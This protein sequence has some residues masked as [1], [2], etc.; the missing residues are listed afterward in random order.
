MSYVIKAADPVTARVLQRWLAL[1][2]K[3]HARHIDEFVKLRPLDPLLCWLVV[4][5]AVPVA[6]V[7]NALGEY[8]WGVVARQ[9]AATP[10]PHRIRFD[11]VAGDIAEFRRRIDW[12]LSE[13][14]SA[15]GMQWL[16]RGDASILITACEAALEAGP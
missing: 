4:M 9:D 15:Y 6:E 14:E 3:K 13:C 7:L 8:G 12:A 2:A 10:T 1:D 16:D 11:D 5:R